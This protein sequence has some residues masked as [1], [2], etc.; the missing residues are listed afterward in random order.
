MRIYAAVR[1]IALHF[2]AICN[3]LTSYVDVLVILLFA[4]NTFFLIFDG[5][6]FLNSDKH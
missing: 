1:F 5:Y 2:W 3:G 4:L 6:S